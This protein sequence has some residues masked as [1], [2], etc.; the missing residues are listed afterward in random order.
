MFRT[1]TFDTDFKTVP[2]VYQILMYCMCP[3]AILEIFECPYLR[4]GSSDQFTFVSRAY[5]VHMSIY[6]IF[7]LITN[8][9]VIY[10]TMSDIPC[11]L[12]FSLVERKHD[13]MLF[14]QRQLLISTFI[15]S[16]YSSCFTHRYSHWINRITLCHIELWGY[17]TWLEIWFTSLICVHILAFWHCC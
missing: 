8:H 11:F 4:N 10:H 17:L 15:S 9:W 16:F 12:L 13:H 1:L 14:E 7:D 3:A 2:K 6:L 5:D